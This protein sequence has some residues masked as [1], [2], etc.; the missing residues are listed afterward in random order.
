M[1]TP[2]IDDH[3][4]NLDPL[5]SQMTAETFEAVV[6]EPATPEELSMT[7]LINGVVQN[8]NASLLLK[9]II[10]RMIL[11]DWEGTQETIN[12]AVQNHVMVEEADLL[13]M[14]VKDL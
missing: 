10:H 13:D 2:M 1:K 14:K 8:K 6:N 12:Q 7:Q 11:I 5:C 9:S 3:E 4:I